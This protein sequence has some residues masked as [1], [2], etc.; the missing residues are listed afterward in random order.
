MSEITALLNGIINRLDIQGANME[1]MKQDIS[2]LKGDVTGLKDDVAS[3]KDDVT[4]I[5]K[6]ISQLEVSVTEL[7]D[8][9]NVLKKD[10]TVL[11]K[12]TADLK[13]DVANIKATQQIH[14]QLLKDLLEEQQKHNKVIHRLSLRSIRHEQDIDDLMQKTKKLP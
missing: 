11:K 2:I 7:K 13:I 4:K 14:S 8:D 9:V 6:N 12:E 1:Q 10:V 3:L 5:K